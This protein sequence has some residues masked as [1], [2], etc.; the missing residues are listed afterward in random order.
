MN[1]KIFFAHCYNIFIL[2]STLSDHS[3]LREIG[4]CIQLHCSYPMYRVNMAKYFLNQED[5]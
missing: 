1:L 2:F 3:P 4:G 5:F